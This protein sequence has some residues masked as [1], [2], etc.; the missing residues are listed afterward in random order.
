MS[1]ATG[2]RTPVI[3]FGHGTRSVLAHAFPDTRMPTR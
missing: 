3:F 1:I 2:A